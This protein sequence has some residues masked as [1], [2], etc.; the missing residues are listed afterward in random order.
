[1]L[2]YNVFFLGGGAQVLSKDKA[3]EDWSADGRLGE[4]CP[5]STAFRREE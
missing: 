4:L 2:H 1:M 3:A 5:Y